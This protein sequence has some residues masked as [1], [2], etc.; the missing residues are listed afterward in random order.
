MGGNKNMIP[1]TSQKEVSNL[2]G[3]VYYYQH[4]LAIHLHTLEPSTKLNQSKVIFKWNEVKKFKTKFS[5]L[6]PVIIY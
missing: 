4:M 1:L 2:I 5:G 6:W 3:V